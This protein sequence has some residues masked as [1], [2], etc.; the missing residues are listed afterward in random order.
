M[1][2]QHICEVCGKEEILSPDEAFEAGW[3]YPPRIG[4][5][6]MIS[7]RTCGDCGIDETLWWA[8][9]VLRT[10]ISDL[11]TNQNETLQRILA[12]PESI[13]VTN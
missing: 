10:Q 13:Y 4:A 9:T 5:F 6:K 8:L 3:D 12:E 7:P 2:L 1:I 11:T